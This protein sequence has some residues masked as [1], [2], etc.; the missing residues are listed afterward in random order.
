MTFDWSALGLVAVVGIGL[1]VATVSTFCLGITAL[2]RREDAQENGTGGAAV[3]LSGA[4]ACFALCAAAVAFG[5][6]L[7]VA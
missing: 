7:I 6:Y 3:A 4:V 2:S 1:T 5:I